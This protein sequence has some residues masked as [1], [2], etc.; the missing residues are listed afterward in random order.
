MSKT[1]KGLLRAG[2][3]LTCLSNTK[4]CAR[5]WFGWLLG[6]GELILT[7]RFDFLRV[8]IL[9]SKKKRKKSFKDTV[10]QFGHFMQY[11]RQELPAAATTGIKY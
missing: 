11:A 5:I 6:G 7:S 2:Q 3:H 1:S 4:G 10:F 9:S 8:G